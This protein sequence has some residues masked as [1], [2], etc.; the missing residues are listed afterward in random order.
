MTDALKILEAVQ[1]E[2]MAASG[3]SLPVRAVFNMLGQLSFR[4]GAEF[5]I[6]GACNALDRMMQIAALA[7]SEL[8]S[9][10]AENA[11]PNK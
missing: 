5:T 9:K 1:Q 6:D 2:A 4:H 8:Q 11:D 3:G 10:A 7:K